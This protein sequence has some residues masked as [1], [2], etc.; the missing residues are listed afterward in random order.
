MKLAFGGG[1]PIGHNNPPLGW[2]GVVRKGLGWIGLI[3]SMEGDTC[4]PCNDIK[5]PKDRSNLDHIFSGE[6]GHF[7]QDTPA[8]R[9][10]ILG[11]IQPQF[12]VGVNPYGVG[13]YR[14]LLPSGSQVWVEVYNYQISNAGINT[15]P[16]YGL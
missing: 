13:V 9:A 14:Q 3:F 5:F 11:A 6:P 8:N 10:L 1:P 12:F 7:A 2:W 15:T 16:R 4:Q